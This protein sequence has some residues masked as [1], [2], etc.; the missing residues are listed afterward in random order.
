MHNYLNRIQEI[1]RPL[2]YF[3]ENSILDVESEQYLGAVFLLQNKRVCFRKAK[4]TPKKIGQFV[5]T[6]TRAQ[7]GQTRPY[8]VSDGV[9]I[10]VIHA[11]AY[12]KSGQFVFSKEVCV[13]YGFFSTADQEGKRGF[14]VY[15][16]WDMPTNTQAQRTQDWQLQHFLSLSP[17]NS[18][19]S[20]RADFLYGL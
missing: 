14:R 7:D 8:N 6:W 11:E 13:K 1:Y 5:A 4:I 15:P 2:G 20:Q 3:L 19:L 18:N 17:E 12:D 10:L 9:D 16:P